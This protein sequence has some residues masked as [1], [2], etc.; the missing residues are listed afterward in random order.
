M[1][2]NE[3]PSIIERIELLETVDPFAN[4]HIAGSNN[5]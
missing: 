1:N 2:D 5:G 4:A 3:T